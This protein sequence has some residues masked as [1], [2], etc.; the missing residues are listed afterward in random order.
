MID[1]AHLDRVHAHVEDAVANGA[2]LLTGGKPRPDVG[3]LF[4]APTVLTDV[5]EEMRLCR[6]ETFG[7]VT[8]I[9][10]YTDIAE[11]VSR[12]TT[13]NSGSTSACGLATPPGARYRH[14]VGRGIG[15]RQRRA[16]GQLG[17]T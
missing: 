1:Q 10:G 6:E 16:G 13:R 17:L 7:P 11:A 5:T 15:H 4:Y 14:Q 8:T 9:Y 3:P 12:A 2:T